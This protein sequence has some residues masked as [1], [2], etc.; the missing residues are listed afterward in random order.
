M[1]KNFKHLL[2][3]L[4]T[5]WLSMIKTLLLYESRMVLYSDDFFRAAASNVCILYIIKPL[6]TEQIAN[7]MNWSIALTATKRAKDKGTYRYSLFFVDNN[8]IINSFN[9]VIYLCVSK[10]PCNCKYQLPN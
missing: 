5:L 10:T 8:F 4:I 6:N 1:S 7:T 3:A 9:F 2:F